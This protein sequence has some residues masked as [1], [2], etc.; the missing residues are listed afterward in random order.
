MPRAVAARNRYRGD[1]SRV[2]LDCFQNGSVGSAANIAMTS[3]PFPPMRVPG[4]GT[5]IG[6]PQRFKGMGHITADSRPTG[7]EWRKPPVDGLQ[8]SGLKGREP[9]VRS[10]LRI[11]S[12][13]GG[14]IQRVNGRFCGYFLPRFSHAADD[15]HREAQILRRLNG[16]TRGL[17]AC[18]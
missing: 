18:R 13:D 7:N 9:R 3:F 5:P 16:R 2:G 1:R 11:M 17:N 15:D 4:R 12:Q 8:L 10:D 6:Q 14:R